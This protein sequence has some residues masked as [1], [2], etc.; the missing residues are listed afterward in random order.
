MKKRKSGRQRRK[1]RVRRKVSGTGERPRL[2]LFRSNRHMYAQMIDDVAGQTLVAA[3]TLSA[4]IKS[5]LAGMKGKREAAKLVGATIAEMAK[6]KGIERVVF[7][8]SGYRYHGCVRALAEA[9]REG[10]LKF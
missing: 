4:Q 1:L 6:Q 9:L 7:D 5:R 10:G 3:T 2:S 8:R